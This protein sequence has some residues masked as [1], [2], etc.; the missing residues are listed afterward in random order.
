MDYS[1]IISFEVRIKNAAPSGED[2]VI[3]H[4]RPI[5]TGFFALGDIAALSFFDPG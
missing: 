3:V 2:G 5:Y 4:L 1:I